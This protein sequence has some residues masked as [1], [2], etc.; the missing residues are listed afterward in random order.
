MQQAEQSSLPFFSM[1][2]H[3]CEPLLSIC[4]STFFIN[5]GFVKIHNGKVYFIVRDEHNVSI[6]FLNNGLVQIK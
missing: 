2:T 1:K 3:S 6:P 4:Q 5:K